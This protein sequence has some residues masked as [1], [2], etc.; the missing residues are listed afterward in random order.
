MRSSDAHSLRV[1]RVEIDREG[2][3]DWAVAQWL[4]SGH[5]FM[6][7]EIISDAWSQRTYAH[8]LLAVSW[9]RWDRW[10]DEVGAAGGGGAMDA[11]RK[12]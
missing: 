9:E 12:S 2:R 1:A 5:T 4:I 11:G 6:S 7:S 8:R 3:E 10:D